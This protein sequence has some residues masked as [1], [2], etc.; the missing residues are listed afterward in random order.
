MFK[1][2]KRPSV[3]TEQLIPSQPNYVRERRR[4]PRELPAAYEVTEGNDEADWLLWE[5]SVSFQDSKMPCTPL[6]R[7]TA[8]TP[9]IA[10]NGHEDVTDAFQSVLKR[11]P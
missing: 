6:S 11:A 2:F 10:P 4:F 5:E 3:K 9:E 8:R 1:L 7:V